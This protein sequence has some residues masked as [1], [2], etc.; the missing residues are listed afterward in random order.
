MTMP[1]ATNSWARELSFNTFITF[2]TFSDLPGDI[3]APSPPW[4]ILTHAS[5]FKPISGFQLDTSLK[6]MESK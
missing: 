4:Q 3:S 5:F 2:N 6:E 1:K